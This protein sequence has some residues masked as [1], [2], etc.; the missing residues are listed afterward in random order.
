MKS[1]QELR[2]LMVPTECPVSR[3]FTSYVS[4]IN[5]IYIYNILIME[6]TPYFP[7]EYIYINNLNN[8]LEIQPKTLTVGITLKLE[9]K[10]LTV[11]ETQH[12]TLSPI[13]WLLSTD[14]TA[15]RGI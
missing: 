11:G 7:K 5:N 1:I 13:S 2:E 3:A 6:S 8:Y 15:I 10:G 12:Q 4:L 9:N 14:T